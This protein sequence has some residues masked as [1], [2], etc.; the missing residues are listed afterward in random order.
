MGSTAVEQENRLA[1]TM[2]LSE[3]ERKFRYRAGAF[4]ATVGATSAIAG[5]S[6]AIMSAKKS[7]PKYFDKGLH[8]SIALHEAGTSLALR[9]LGWGT[10]YA[11]LGTGTICFGIW[12][13]SGAKDM[14]EFRESVGRVFPRVPKNDPPKSRT[15]FEGLTDLMQYL[16]TWGKD[17]K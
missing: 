7:D 10:L 11:I 17:E 15:E 5:F 1:P 14:K 12:K 6:K 2:E 8:G 9:A 13:L 16:S 3:D 4:L